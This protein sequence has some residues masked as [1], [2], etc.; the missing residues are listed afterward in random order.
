[1]MLTSAADVQAALK[2]LPPEYLGRRRVC[3][4]EGLS[5]EEIAATGGQARHGAQPIYC[6]GGPSRALLLSIAGRPGR[7][8]PRS[9]PLVEPAPRYQGLPPPRSGDS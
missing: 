3:V 5:Y 9:D 8:G 1:M 7:R 2:A 6:A 4:F